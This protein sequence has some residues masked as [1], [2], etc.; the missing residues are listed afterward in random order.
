MHLDYTRQ[1]AAK[2]RR[3]TRRAARRDKSAR[4]FLAIAFP[5]TLDA[6]QPVEGR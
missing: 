3:M 2:A 1:P 4:L 6:F 5:A